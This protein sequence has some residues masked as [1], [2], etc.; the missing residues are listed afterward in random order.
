MQHR[1]TR[2]RF[3]PLAAGTVLAAATLAGCGSTASTANSTSS[4]PSSASSPET[5][6][7]TASGG[8]RAMAAGACA[9]RSF[10]GQDGY[11]YVKFFY[12]N[13]LTQIISKGSQGKAV[14]EAQC[15]LSYRKCSP[16][17]IDGIFGKNTEAA[18][19]S[20]QKKNGLTADGSI[21]PKTWPKLRLH[22]PGSPKNC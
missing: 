21:G 9:D 7:S 4:A 6:S 16:G 2:N 22:S 5:A 19:I 11:T 12:T 1:A 18:V 10:F 17:Q 15:L 20:F 8:M 13:T 14:W 3:G